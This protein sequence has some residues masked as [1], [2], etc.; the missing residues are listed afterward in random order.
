MKLLFCTS[1]RDVFSLKKSEVKCSCLKSGG[2]YLDD[3]NAEYY[4]PCIPL[5]FNNVSFVKA[6]SE[7]LQN[8][9]LATGV[10]FIA[11]VVPS[12][13]Y[14]FRRKDKNDS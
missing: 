4:G 7:T 13:C 11:F 1:C 6:W 9:T 8:C 12:T 10:R 3:I 2:K 14:T 5:G